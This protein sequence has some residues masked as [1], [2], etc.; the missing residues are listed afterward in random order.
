MVRSL[1]MLA[2]ALLGVEKTECLDKAVWPAFCCC[3]AR[4]A[5]KAPRVWRPFQQQVRR[6]YRWRLGACSLS[7]GEMGAPLRRDLRSNLI[8]NSDVSQLTAATQ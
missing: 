3:W 1:R 4:L 2:Q 5:A 8:H 7:L 6:S